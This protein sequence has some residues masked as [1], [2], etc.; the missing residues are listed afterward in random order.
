MRHGRSTRSALGPAPGSRPDTR[1]VNLGQSVSVLARP[2]FHVALRVVW[3]S[4]ERVVGP[5]R[6]HRDS[7]A[8]LLPDV[9]WAYNFSTGLQIVPRAGLP[10]GV[11][12]SRGQHAVFTY[13]NL[14]QPLDA[15]R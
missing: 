1:A 15:L 14:E 10:I 4:Y 2:L 11:R 6:T 8:F 9:S 5:G 3:S 13:L 7:S 12:T